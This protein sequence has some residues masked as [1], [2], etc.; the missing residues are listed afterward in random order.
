MSI[1][2]ISKSVEKTYGQPITRAKDCDRLAKD[3]E[4]VTGRPISSATLRRMFGLLKTK[5]KLSSYNQETIQLYIA[6]KSELEEQFNDWTSPD[7]ETVVAI[8]DI[9]LEKYEKPNEHLVDYLLGLRI[10]SHTYYEVLRK[11]ILLSVEESHNEFIV[12]LYHRPHHILESSKVY[13]TLGE[14]LREKNEGGLEAIGLLAQTPVARRQFFER[15]VDMG[16]FSIYRKWLKIFID[17]EPVEMAK[18][19]AES[20][21]IYGD[22]L[23][24]RPFN[25]N[26]L[27]DLIN[28]HEADIA[29]IHPYVAARLLGA[30][31]L[32]ESEAAA[33]LIKKRLKNEAHNL[34]K[35]PGN[36]PLFS[37]MLGQYLILS[38]D[39]SLGKESLHNL[40]SYIPTNTSH[41]DQGLPF[42]KKIM[43]YFT[44]NDVSYTL[45]E[46][47]NFNSGHTNDDLVLKY[48]ASK[49]A[50]DSY[51]KVKDYQ[52]SLIAASGFKKLK[53]IFA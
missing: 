14:K 3:I 37:V 16:H 53:E 34:K 6:G 11:L 26:G 47:K 23:S 1:Q 42:L 2:N 50:V 20:L 38:G 10:P 12:R 39:H 32:L 18:H 43:E 13:R 17:H 35:N 46:V 52:K 29:K 51:G 25:A 9:L 48:Y 15:F 41:I 22:F 7:E 30:T 33:N 28:N 8:L 44:G 24:N 4:Q 31:L 19:W 36:P 45:D 21:L 40:K 27:L 49:Y 5:S